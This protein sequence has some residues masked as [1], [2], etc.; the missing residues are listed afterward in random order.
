MPQSLAVKTTLPE[1]LLSLCYHHGVDFWGLSGVLRCALMACRTSVVAE[2]ASITAKLEWFTRSNS[3]FC[4]KYSPFF[5]KLLWYLCTWLRCVIWRCLNQSFVSVVNRYVL[6]HHRFGGGSL[7]CWGKYP[8][9]ASPSRARGTGIV[10]GQDSVQLRVT[11]VC[12]HFLG[13]GSIDVMNCTSPL[14]RAE[15]NQDPESFIHQHLGQRVEAFVFS[16][17]TSELQTGRCHSVSHRSRFH[18]FLY[19]KPT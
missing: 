11:G 6:Q 19:D 10:R 16:R 1:E 15:S 4:A 13:N 2:L 17:I 12:Q 18:L 3:S 7:L 14:P 9:R 5:I 8:W